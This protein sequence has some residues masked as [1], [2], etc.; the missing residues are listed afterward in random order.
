MIEIEGIN[1]KKTKKEELVRL[2][3]EENIKNPS[4]KEKKNLQRVI[5]ESIENGQFNTARNSIVLG[6]YFDLDK[7]INTIKKKG[8]FRYSNYI[9]DKCIISNLAIEIK[10]ILTDLNILNQ[11]LH[12]YLE[13]KIHFKPIYNSLKDLSFQI[14]RELNSFE[15]K[16]KGKSLIKTLLSFIDLIFLNNYYPEKVDQLIGLENRT[17][18]EIS[19]A[20][21]YVIFIYTDNIPTE[22]I[23]I[24]FISEEYIISNN[25]E[26]LLLPACTLLDL[27]GFEVMIDSFDYKCLKFENKIKIIPPSADFEKSI[28]LGYIRTLIQAQNDF[29]SMSVPKEALSFNDIIEELLKHED[30]IL[31]E[32]VSTYDYPRYVLKVDEHAFDIVFANLLKPDYFFREEIIYCL[33]IFKEQLLN[34]IELKNV[35]LA[36]D[37]TLLDFIKIRR[38]FILLYSL[39]TKQ[40][41]KKEGTNSELVLRS[42]VPMF[43][44]E[45]IFTFVK[46]LTTLEKL[47]TFLD[48]VTWSPEDLFLFDLQYHPVLLINN[49]NLIPLA[50]FSS[51]NFIRNLFASQHKQNNKHLLLDGKDDPLIEMMTRSFSKAGIK[52]YKET[53]IP[54]SDIDLFIIWKDTM[55]VF[56]CKHTLHPVS[57]FDLRTTYDYI[58][59]AEKQLSY[60][61]ELFDKGELLPIL[62]KYNK[63]DLSNITKIHFSIVLS[64]RLF[65]GDVF[66][67]PV[68]NFNE[69]DNVL[70]RGTLRTKDGEFYIWKSKNLEL[71]DLVD[72]FSLEN[73]SFAF[74]YNLLTFKTINYNS[75]GIEVLFDSYYLDQKIADEKLNEYTSK[76]IK[77]EH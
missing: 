14:V 70:N 63:I 71:V 27:K 33:Q 3:K 47:D 26:K 67:Y 8:V 15:K 37:F 62:E 36:D 68:R 42:L 23:D 31:F 32:K 76:M 1:L 48:I 29:N 16:H 61:N 59:K 4:I 51:S 39:Y 13:S 10:E 24:Q 75:S 5:N 22:K 2:L 28:R 56:E 55:F 25:I 54:K 6:F 65:T 19:S 30:I 44:K 41:I 35:K 77:F 40:L 74:L 12:N 69:I 45:K 60:V 57:A 11:D 20:I 66:K 46:K 21:S 72:Y 9:N 34:P 52:S 58:K 53:P 38:A 7:T 18:E 17:K 73:E 64:N 43:D 49:K 50:I